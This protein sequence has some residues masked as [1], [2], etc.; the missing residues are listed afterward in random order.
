MNF[1]TFKHAVSEQ[2]ATIMRHV[3]FRT[4]VSKDD[5]WHT[6][7]ASFP[8]G[9][10]PLYRE[11][12]EHDCSCCRQFIKAVGNVVAVIDGKLVSV[13][14]VSLTDEPAY[15]A[16]ADALSELVKRHAIADR[17]K[18][19]ENHAG[20]DKNFEEILGEVKQWDHFYVT[21]PKALVVAKPNMPSVLGA[22][23]DD[24]AVL[25][26]LLKETSLE[27]VDTLLELIEQN[28]LYRGAENKAALLSLRTVLARYDGSDTAAW[29]E[30]ASL[31]AHVSRMRN[32]AFGTLLQ[33]LAA[34]KSLDD[35]V[36]AYETMVAPQNYK[37]PT[38]LVTKKMVER[39]K[40]QLQELNLLSALERRHAVLK[41]INVSNL[42]YVDRSAKKRPSGDVFDNLAVAEKPKTF[43]KVAEMPIETFIKEVLPGAKSVEAL[44]ENKHANNLVT[45]L[46]AADPTAESL[47]KWGN[48]F[49][50]TYAGNFA[51][52]IKERVKSAGGAIEGDVMCRLAWDY[53][54]DL[55]FHMQEPGG[56]E[57]YFGVRR[58]TSPNGGMLDVDANGIDGIR[59]DPVENIVYK[60]SN[61]MR[62]GVYQLHVHNF[63]RRSE[64]VG[65]E[66][67]IEVYGETYS[68][69]YPKVVRSKERLHIANI[70]VNNRTVK[71]EPVMPAGPRNKIL[72]SLPTNS[73]HKVSSVMLSPNHWEE[74]KGN[75]HY[76]F[77]LE[78]CVTAEPVRGFFNEYLKDSLTPHRKVMEMVGSKVKPEHSDNQLSG[79]GFSSTKRD[80]VL[81][82]VTGAF[83]RTVKVTF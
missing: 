52:S 69:D 68:F 14:D 47:F 79:L 48:S 17:F 59:P 53:S 23:R 3:S 2:F 45:L 56:F 15:Q 67:E 28:S 54:D 36:R 77:M 38:A 62:D 6:Y 71:V 66:V 41:D 76:F 22:L 60:T 33:D 35:A 57:V 19:Y 73:F 37:R 13:W 26:R 46:T 43:S 20:T 32:T 63:A 49:S 50:W 78:N 39:A 34:G 83:T 1:Q 27:D 12:T 74:Q 4:S 81:L 75:Q 7:L 25:G 9:S 10:N 82:R 11:R 44:L 18:H 16:V 29:V 55:D 65:F 31:P 64:G 61:T 30:A 42:L 40:A 8:E 5:L 72:W 24:A 21:I 70:V 58:Q 51:D 80:S